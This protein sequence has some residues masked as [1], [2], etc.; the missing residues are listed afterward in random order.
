MRAVSWLETA[1]PKGHQDASGRA[2]RHGR[3]DSAPYLGRTWRAARRVL[4]GSNPDTRQPRSAREEGVHVQP[5][6]R[7][8]IILPR[9]CRGAIGRHGLGDRLGRPTDG[10]H[11]SIWPRLREG[12]LLRVARKAGRSACPDKDTSSKKGLRP[13]SAPVPYP[14]GDFPLRQTELQP[15]GH[16]RDEVPT[17]EELS[18][19]RHSVRL[20]CGDLPRPE[21]EGY[22][23]QSRSLGTAAPQVS[24]SN[25]CSAGRAIESE[26]TP[27]SRP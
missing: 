10:H 1:K 11:W 25:S 24:N 16:P 27:E 17:A 21:D 26:E 7:R 15:G 6:P 14:T 20:L 23:N 19:A 12:C 3:T 9:C 13:R 4:V 18:R 22:P 2:G 5:G 8:P